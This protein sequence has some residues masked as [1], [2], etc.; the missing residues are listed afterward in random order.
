[1]SKKIIYVLIAV[2]IIILGVYSLRDDNSGKKEV[3]KIG[4]VAPVSGSFAAYGSTLAKGVEMAAK[5]MSE[6]NTKYTY[7]V[8]VEDDESTPAK[9]ASA[10]S[11]LINID[12][13]KAIITTTSGSGN[14]VKNQAEKAG[15]IHICDCS[16]ATIGNAAYNFTNLMLPADEARKWVQEAKNR[17]NKTIALLTVTQAG[18]ITLT[19]AILPEI[20]SQGLK[21]V[22]KESFAPETRDFNTIVAK[23]K[24]SGADI[25]LVIA[26]PPALDILTKGLLSAGIKNISTT[27]L[28]TTSPSPEIYNGLWFTDA[29][30]TDIK[31]KERFS[32][33][34]PEIRF[35]ARTVPYGYDI[36]NMLVQSFEQGGDAYANLKAITEYNGKVGKITKSTDS[37]NFRSEASIWTMVN[38]V[39]EMVK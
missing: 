3:I 30:L 14:A 29:T 20:E 5:D 22:Y 15:V 37:Q 10:A 36:F 19:N 32:T 11:K 24:N 18:A 8:I 16:D 9:S 33:L 34:Y 38:G 28:F 26:Y 27:G 1:M 2:V 25:F 23:S 31:L 7:E 17:G 35:N 6:K 12:K 13:V 39:A 4:V 21:I